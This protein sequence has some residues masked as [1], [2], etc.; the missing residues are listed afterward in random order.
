M[1]AYWNNLQ[2]REQLIVAFASVTLLLLI[3]YLSIIE[4]HINNKEQLRRS[5]QIQQEDLQWMRE[6]ALQFN[7]QKSHKGGLGSGQS[8][9]SAVDQSVRKQGLSSAIKK[10]QPEGKRVRIQFEQVAFDRMISWLSQVEQQLG[11]RVEGVVVERQEQAG[12]VNAR[13]VIGSSR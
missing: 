13:V 8:L 4:P 9:M 2:P 12:A 11:L 6:T 10:I 3:I 5:V 1:N 7:G